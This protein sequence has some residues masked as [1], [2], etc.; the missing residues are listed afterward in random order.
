ML[1]NSTAF[2]PGG[3]LEGRK[4]FINGIYKDEEIER[5]FV[6]KYLEDGMVALD[7]GAHHGFYTLIASK[8]VGAKGQV[9]AFEPSPREYR[10]LTQH[11]KLNR[12][13][14]VMAV[15]VAVSDGEGE[16]T[17][18]IV[19]KGDTGRNSIIY[20]PIVE[21]ESV[22]SVTV[23]TTSLNKYLEE[24]G[25]K[26]VDFIKVDAEGSELSIFKGAQRLLGVFPRP[27]ILCEL[28]DS[29][30]QA[31]G[32]SAAHIYKFLAERNFIWFT[33]TNS[34]KLLHHPL[35]D[36]FEA[37]FMAVPQ[38]RICKLKEMGFIDEDSTLTTTAIVQ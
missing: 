29:C 28:R 10:R 9:I 11:I 36:Q 19:E 6:E 37:N 12:R 14:N 23:R 13:H 22:R 2:H 25:V 16:L 24:N 17:L 26:N 32:Y 18:F 27:I 38:E 20:R 21:A 34:G 8:R 4:L 3:A 31:W 30:T 35:T 7:I 1:L 15:P 33:L 5:R